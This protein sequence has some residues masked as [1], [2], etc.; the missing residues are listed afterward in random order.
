MR[1]GVALRAG[2]EA[3]RRSAARAVEAE[4]DRAQAIFRV[5]LL[6]RDLAQARQEWEEALA[7]LKKEQELKDVVEK[8]TGRLA[9]EVSKLSEETSTLRGV[10]GHLEKEVSLRDETFQS[11]P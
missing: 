5:A 9:E 7:I 4:V 1:L 11:D 8:I 2:E 3:G 10:V 6:E